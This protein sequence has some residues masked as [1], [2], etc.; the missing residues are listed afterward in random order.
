MSD[1]TTVVGEQRSFSGLFLG[2]LAVA[3]VLAIAGLGWSYYLSGRLTHA[4]TQ[5]SQAQQQ[6][7]KLATALDE[8]NARLKVTSDTLGHSL[9]LT[10]KQLELKAQEL[11]RRQ[12]AD[13]TRIQ[14]VETQQQATQKAVSTVSSDVSSVKTDVGGVK[15]DLTN[16]QSELK[17]AETQLQS[18]KG[19]LGLQ[20]GLI[21]TNHD[22]LEILKHKGDRNYYEFTLSKGQRKPVSTVSLELKKADI[23]HSRYTLDVYAD[24][25]KIEK[26][27]RGL[28]EPVQFY[29]GKD[30]F[31][32]ELVVNSI[33]KNTIKGYISTPKSAPAPVSTS[34]Q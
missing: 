16:T 12:Q 4:E 29:T 15:S 13:A 33:D 5:L 11:L 10:Q 1:E 34:G 14:S 7:D 26:K 23:K 31:L 32:Y 19:D 21:A 18:M 20:S 3:V 2:L 30:N 22:E 17:T 27:D 25:K 9:G 8:T 28:N 24:D 6:N